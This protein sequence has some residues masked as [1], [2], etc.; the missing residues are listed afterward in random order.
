MQFAFFAAKKALEDAEW[1]PKN[2]NE[3][4]RTVG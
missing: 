2:L 4:I 1:E 3:R